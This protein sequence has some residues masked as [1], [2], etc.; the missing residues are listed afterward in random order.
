MSVGHR[1]R[2]KGEVLK[3]VLFLVLLLQVLVIDA[4]AGSTEDVY[5]EMR[6][7]FIH[8]FVEKTKELN[9]EEHDHALKVLEEQLRVIVGPIKVAGFAERGAINLQTLE[10][11]DGGFNQVD[12]LM[13][14]S[15]REQLFVT[16]GGLLKDYLNRNKGLPE[17]FNQLSR[18]EE[19]YSRVFD[20]DS[21]FTRFAEI[22]IKNTR[23]FSITRAFLTLNAQDI[24]PFIPETVIVFV[25]KGNRVLL[26]KS[27]VQTIQI[28]ACKDQWD[29]FERKSSEALARY[30]SS[31]R[32]DRIAWD[33]HLRFESEGF[34]A[35]RRCYERKIKSEKAFSRLTDQVQSI[36]DRLQNPKRE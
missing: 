8:Q 5:L 31:G 15:E 29:R 18:S 20:W 6:D 26:F 2:D 34:E 24:G 22:P 32:T 14:S 23:G 17:D 19:F 1:L 35:Y 25:A 7:R 3:Y 10:R 33:D 12:G 27:E 9:Y 11:G 36:V 4:V 30:H 13:F 21:A 16:T 28:P